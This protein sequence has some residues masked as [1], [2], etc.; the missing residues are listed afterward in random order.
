[1]SSVEYIG[2]FREFRV[3]RGGVDLHHNVMGKR[4]KALDS[5]P[6]FLFC[7]CNEDCY[8]YIVG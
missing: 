4:G 3:F 2:A 7:I 6:F 1:M 5:E 8:V